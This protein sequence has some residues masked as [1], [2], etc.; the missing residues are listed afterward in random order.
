MKLAGECSDLD[1]NNG[2]VKFLITVNDGK[3]QQQ[4]WF[5]VLKEYIDF[6]PDIPVEVIVRNVS[7]RPNPTAQDG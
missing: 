5:N 2:I 7:K 6:D 1:Y 4:A 3:Q